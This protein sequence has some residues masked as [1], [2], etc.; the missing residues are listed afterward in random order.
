MRHHRYALA[1]SVTAIALL[2]TAMPSHAQV[3]SNAASADTTPDGLSLSEVVVTAGDLVQLVPNLQ[4][5]GVA[6]RTSLL[7]A[8]V[9][10]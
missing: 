1:L 8:I 6:S 3:T 7:H 4:M 10:R 9:S 2:S 5:N